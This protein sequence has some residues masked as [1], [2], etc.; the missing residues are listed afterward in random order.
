MEPPVCSQSVRST[1]SN[2]GLQLASGMEGDLV[3]LSPLPV[4]PDSIPVDSVRIELN[5][6]TLCWHRRIA[7]WCG[8]ASIPTFWNWVQEV[9]SPFYSIPQ[10]K[11]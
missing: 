5:S 4:E 7:C 11:C 2:L 1:G 10:G 9:F 6:Q 3:G 8:E